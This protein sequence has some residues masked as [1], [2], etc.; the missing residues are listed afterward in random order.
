MFGEMGDDGVRSSETGNDWN[1]SPKYKSGEETEEDEEE[2]DPDLDPSLGIGTSMTRSK[3]PCP[4]R[5]VY[6]PN[7]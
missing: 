2:E 6:L 5:R 4:F 7:W 3:G 1:P